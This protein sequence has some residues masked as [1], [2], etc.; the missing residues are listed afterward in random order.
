MTPDYQSKRKPWKHQETIFRDSCNRKSWAFFMEQGTGKSMV[1]VDTAAW[2]FL[3]ETVDA[4]LVVSDKNITRV[5]QEEHLPENMPDNVPYKSLI[6]DASM[7]RTKKGKAALNDLM[8]YSGMS[9]LLT[10][11]A[12]FRVEDGKRFIKEF[13]LRRS[14]IMQLDESDAIKSPRAKQTKSITALGRYATMRRIATG[15]PV[16]EGRL[17]YSH[18]CDSLTRLFS[19]NHR[20]WLFGIGT[21][22]SIRFDL[23]TVNRFPFCSIIRTLTNCTIS[24]SNTEVVF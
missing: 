24:W 19:G 7:L 21:A 22:Y 4:M 23:A 6:L 13:L 9:I 11:W 18:R 20:S 1:M 3:N 12:M 10:N 14:V 2:N 8:N 5:W 17:T 15:T 16:A